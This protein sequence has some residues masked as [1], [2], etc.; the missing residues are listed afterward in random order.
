MQKDKKINVIKGDE[1]K[2]IVIIDKY[3]R[4]GK[5]QGGPQLNASIKYDKKEEGKMNAETCYCYK[6]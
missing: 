5:K 4:V 1:C 2:K 6:K 3:K